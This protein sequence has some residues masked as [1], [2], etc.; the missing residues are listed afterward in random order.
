LRLVGD[1]SCAENSSTAWSLCAFRWPP[2]RA[3]ENRNPRRAVW[4]CSA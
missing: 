3:R 4:Y 2:P 1:K